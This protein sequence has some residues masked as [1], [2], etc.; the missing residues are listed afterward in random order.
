M[1]FGS[2]TKTTCLEVPFVTFKNWKTNLCR[3]VLEF[4]NDALIFQFARPNLFSFR[5]REMG[6]EFRFFC[7]KSELSSG[8]VWKVEVSK[9][10]WLF[11]I[12]IC[13]ICTYSFRT[14]GA[15][16]IRQHKDRSYLTGIIILFRSLRLQW[17]VR[18]NKK[19]IG[20]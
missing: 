18:R 8:V 19:Q 12:N 4:M 7:E 2:S 11:W 13:E 20:N 10:W 14:H 3:S 6:I 16:F 5:Q 15:L 17:L 1:L 9:G